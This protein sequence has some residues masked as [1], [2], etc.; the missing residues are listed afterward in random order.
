MDQL[1]TVYDDRIVRIKGGLL[2]DEGLGYYHSWA[3]ICVEC[4]PVKDRIDSGVLDSHEC[5]RFSDDHQNQLPH[6][7]R[8]QHTRYLRNGKVPIFGRECK[9][10]VAAA[11]GLGFEVGDIG[12]N[13]GLVRETVQYYD[14]E[15]L[16][17][18]CSGSGLRGD[19]EMI[20]RD[21]NRLVKAV[22]EGQTFGY[23]IRG[24]N[25][26]WLNRSNS[27]GTE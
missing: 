13:R 23:A 1:P 26:P 22:G 8:T 2:H 6:R 12:A 17:D 4:G 5:I 25:L 11:T 27:G 7:L 20:F 3:A 24:L 19:N 14:L 10:L 16:D 21:L 9:F 15:A 18:A